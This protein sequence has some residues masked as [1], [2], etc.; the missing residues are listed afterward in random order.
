[1]TNVFT[2]AA[3]VKCP[4][5]LDCLA[6]EITA[7]ANIEIK[8]KKIRI[9]E[10]DGTGLAVLDYYKTIKVVTES[11]AG[12]LGTAYTPI[13]IDDNNTPA[14]A[15]VKTGPMG[16]GTIDKTIDQLSL[17]TNTDFYWAAS[18]EDDKIVIK[19]GGIFALQVNTST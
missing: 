8:I 5:G 7:P 11:A 14:V 3:T 2:V 4:V 15:T 10:G 6:V 9:I 1:M 19:P 16:L 17:H 12:T 13:D 18:D